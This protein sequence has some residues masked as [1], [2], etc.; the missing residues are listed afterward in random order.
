[1]AAAIFGILA[2][3]FISQLLPLF[4]PVVIG[5]IIL[6]IEISL[7]RVGINWAGGGLPTVTSMVDGV[8]GAFPNPPY[9]QL[10]SLTSRCS[11]CW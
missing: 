4:P 8:P 10:Q 1:M 5:T 7:M 2:A 9:G 6:V 3:P 11:C